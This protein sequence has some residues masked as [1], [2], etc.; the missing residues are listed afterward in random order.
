MTNADGQYEI[1]L[2]IVLLFGTPALIGSFILDRHDRRGEKAPAWAGGLQVGG[3]LLT[4][5]AIFA[6]GPV[7][8]EIMHIL[9]R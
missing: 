2:L 8:P 3:V 4:V 7:M 1:Y 6:V 5:L 9:G